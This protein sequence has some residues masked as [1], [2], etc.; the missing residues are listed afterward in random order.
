MPEPDHGPKSI[1]G[2]IYTCELCI[3]ST[4]PM[5]RELNQRISL[6]RPCKRRSFWKVCTSQRFCSCLAL[7]GLPFAISV[8]VSQIFQRP[9][10]RFDWALANNSH[11][12]E[13]VRQH[14][15]TLP[16]F[17]RIL[18]S[19]VPDVF[20]CSHCNDG[21]DELW[22]FGRRRKLPCHSREVQSYSVTK[23]QAWS[24]AGGCCPMW[25]TLSKIGP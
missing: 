8:F 11:A 19:N 2:E 17:A 10:P 1:R 16:T 23:G 22:R 4:K 20:Q 3:R 25:P 5:C 14:F 12:S 9:S 15:E 18:R 21:D 6:P 24:V 7:R 13:I